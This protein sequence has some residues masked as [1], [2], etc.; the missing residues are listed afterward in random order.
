[1]LDLDHFKRINDTWG[2]AAG[3]QVL[4]ATCLR[5]SRVLRGADQIGRLGGEEFGV[6]VAGADRRVARQLAERLRTVLADEPIECGD[7]LGLEVTAS[8]GGATVQGL[9]LPGH[10]AVLRDADRALYASKEGGRNRVTW[11]E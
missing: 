8:F 11:A 1:M 3:D 2:H 5:L 9:D 10:E 6:V 4:R 7:D